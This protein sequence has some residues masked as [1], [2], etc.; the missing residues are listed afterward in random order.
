M[1]SRRPASSRLKPPGWRAAPSARTGSTPPRTYPRTDLS[2]LPPGADA[3][4]PLFVLVE[5]LSR[6]FALPLVWSLRTGA[7]AYPALIAGVGAQPS[8]ASQRL[9]ELREAGLVEVDEGGDYR[10]TTHGRRLLD[11]LEQL[12]DFAGDW[13][14]LSPRQRVP[15]GGAHRGRGER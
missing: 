5:L 3:Q 13:A 11:P 14:A 10:L 7:E 9:R 12:D 15:R 2:G 4:P 6:R 1:S 8:V